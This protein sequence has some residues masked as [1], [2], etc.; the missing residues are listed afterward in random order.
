MIAESWPE[1]AEL[2]MGAI[3]LLALTVSTGKSMM[4]ISYG[5]LLDWGGVWSGEN[6][7]TGT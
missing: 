7:P 5:V 2:H 1:R 6:A 4:T 3:W